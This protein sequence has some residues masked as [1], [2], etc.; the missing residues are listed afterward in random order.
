[1]ICL[2]DKVKRVGENSPTGFVKKI[3]EDSRAVVLWGI[4]DGV[5]YTEVIELAE[6]QH[7]S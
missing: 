3:T 5:E 1:M 6:L 7:A 2:G 4:S